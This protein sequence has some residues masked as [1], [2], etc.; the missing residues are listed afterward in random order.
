MGSLHSISLTVSAE[1]GTYGDLTYTC[2]EDGTIEITGCSSTAV[3]VDIP[4]EINGMDVAGIG[5][6]AFENAINLTHVTFPEGLLYIEEDAFAYCEFITEFFIPSTVERIGERALD[7]DSLTAVHIAENN[8]FY[9]DIDGVLFN[10]ARTELIMYPNEKP[11]NSYRIPDGVVSL[12]ELVFATC[13]QLTSI[14]LSDDVAEIG[15]EAL[16]YCSSLS[17]ICVTENNSWFTSVDGVLFSKDMTRIVRYPEG[18]T[19]TSYKVPDGVRVIG[20]SAFYICNNLYKITLPEGVTTIENYAFNSC[21][22]LSVLNFPDTITQIGE[23]VITFSSALRHI[24]LPK[25]MTSVNEIAFWDSNGLRSITIPTSI[26]IV[27]D[28]AFLNCTNL[29]DIYYEGT[30]S[31]WNSIGFVSYDT[32]FQKATVHMSSSGPDVMQAITG[33]VSMDETIGIDDASMTLSIYANQAAG[34]SNDRYTAGQLI[35]ADTDGAGSI[36]ITDASAI[37]SFYAQNAAGL[38]ANWADVLN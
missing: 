8:A 13:D 12:H 32:E 5:V 17:E 3:T 30:E 24:T 15:T 27:G 28:D 9:T 31:D 34:L 11:G 6:G 21:K 10:K 37:L 22:N 2:L 23:R 4:A 1:T 26:K 33:D 20:D 16:E 29:T 36:D 38:R 7:T 19:R 35:S 25:G 14:T 18:N